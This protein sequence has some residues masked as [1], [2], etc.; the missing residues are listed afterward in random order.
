M[1]NPLDLSPKMVIICWDLT[2]ILRLF[3]LY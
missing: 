2:S 1:F 3:V